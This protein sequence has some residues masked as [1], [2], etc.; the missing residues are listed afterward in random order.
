MEH[1]EEI[2]SDTADY[3]PTK[4]LRYVDDTFV[5]WPH[6][7]ARLQTF[8]HHPN[9]LRLTVKFIMEVEAN[10]ILPFL[11]VLTMK[12]GHK[13]AIKMYRKPIHTGRY[14][15]FSSNHHVT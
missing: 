2:A 12:R 11:N 10:N 7:P 4:W 3:K 15:H 13:L 14:L 1:F 5:V 8:L 6:G 9:N